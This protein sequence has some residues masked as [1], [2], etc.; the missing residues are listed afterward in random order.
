MNKAIHAARAGTVLLLAI[1]LGA[2]ATKLG[3]DFDDAYARQITPGQ[4][5]KADVRNKLGRPLIVTKVSGDDVWTYSYY[6]GGGPG[7]IV[8]S[9]FGQIDLNNPL[10]AQQKR[11]VVTFTG[12]TVKESKFVQELPQP[13][14]LEEAYR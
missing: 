7:V 11:L 2:C 5:T 6:E 9:W 1:T 4:T 8:K 3:L 13:D 14:P 10:G 12:D